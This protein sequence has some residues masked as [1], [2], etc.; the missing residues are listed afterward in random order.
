MKS[1]KLIT[2]LTSL[3][4]GLLLTVEALTFYLI[5][6]LDMLPWQF[7]LVLAALFLL[8]WAGLGAMLFARGKKGFVGN[9]RRIAAMVLTLLVV[10]GCAGISSVVYDVTDTV[11]NITNPGSV[12]TMMTVYVLDENPAQSI[13]DAVD[14]TFGIMG[15]YEESKSTQAVALLNSTVGGVLNTMSYNSAV[16]LAGA[17][18]QQDV[19]A[20]IMSSAYV[21][22]LEDHAM[23]GDFSQRV[24]VLYEIPLT[25]MEPVKQNG[26]SSDE[27]AGSDKPTQ[28]PAV[29]EPGGDDRIDDIT[30]TP[31]LMYIS[32]SD[33]RSAM[34]TTSRSDVNILV[35]VNPE[36]KQVLLLNTPRDYYI[37]NPA[38]GGSLDKLTHCGI[39]GIDC[40]MDALSGLYSHKVDYYAQINFTGFET[41]IDAIGGVTVHSDFTFSAG[42][43]FYIEQGEN[44]LNGE[45]ALAFARERKRLPNGDNDRGK[46]QMQLIKAVIK[47]MTSGTAIA[48]YSGI[49]DSMEG[50]FVTDFSSENISKLVKMQ[51]SDMAS[52]NVQSYAVTGYTGSSETYSMPGEYLSVM[53]C[54]DDMVAFGSDLINKVFDG[55]ILTEQDVIYPGA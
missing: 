43:Q 47:Q 13:E 42:G 9:G 39:Y 25:N 52:W 35:A 22:L 15:G 28:A 48:N 2:V 49:L 8:V 51:L 50:M 31:F 3:I 45:A 20:V 26:N 33:T 30:N 23:F 41:L 12:T 34:L 54:D 53:F 36:T 44:Y 17:L 1:E 24:R 5:V 40:S 27:N 11:T 32:G 18:Y 7:L 46:N 38:G 6:R 21:S 37:P 19:D 10:L 14:H 16:E 4:W 29:N 55:E